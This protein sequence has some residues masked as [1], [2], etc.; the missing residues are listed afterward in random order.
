VSPW[1]VPAKGYK[2]RRRKPSDRFIVSRKKKR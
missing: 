2:T 1:G